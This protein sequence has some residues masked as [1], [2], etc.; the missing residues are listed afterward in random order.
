MDN[1]TEAVAIDDDSNVFSITAPEV[2]A[3][4]EVREGDAEPAA[5]TVATPLPAF[6]DGPAKV[7]VLEPGLIE[8]IGNVR[9]A[10]ERA[11]ASCEFNQVVFQVWLRWHEESDSAFEKDGEA[12]RTGRLGRGPAW[13]QLSEVKVRRYGFT[14]EAWL[15]DDDDER[16][17]VTTRVVLFREL[18]RAT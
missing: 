18:D 9:K 7:V 16:R 15:V 12:V 3:A 14:A 8:L 11:D 10:V 13:E 6:R 1:Q 4:E 2:D 5:L 17:H